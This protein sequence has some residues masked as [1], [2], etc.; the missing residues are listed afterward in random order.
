M[1]L[2]QIM[3][4]TSKYEIVNRYSVFNNIQLLPIDVGTYLTAVRFYPII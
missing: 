4:K 1:F 2:E 3:G